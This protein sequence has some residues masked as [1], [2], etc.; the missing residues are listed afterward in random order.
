[1]IKAK[2][3]I[4]NKMIKFFCGDERTVND[5]RKKTV[6]DFLHIIDSEKL[7]EVLK[8][9]ANKKASF[10]FLIEMLNKVAFD[11]L[12]LIEDSIDQILD[13][14]EGQFNNLGGKIF[15]NSNIEEI[16]VGAKDVI[17]SDKINKNNA[18]IAIIATDNI[19][20]VLGIIDEQYINTEI[21][22]LL[23]FG[24]IFDSYTII[25]FVLKNKISKLNNLERFIIEKPFID[26][27]QAFQRKYETIYRECKEKY[28]L[29]LYMRG[30]YSYWEKESQNVEEIKELITKKCIIETEKYL[31]KFEKNIKSTSVITPIDK[32]KENNVMIGSTRGWIST[33]KYYNKNIEILRKNSK[34][35][36]AK[37]IF[38]TNSKFEK[39][40][41]NIEYLLEEI[42]NS[43]V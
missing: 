23:S 40:L 35:F 21:E 36:A 34:V 16:Y 22:K 26:N 43:R 5:Y 29:S 32:F 37:T 39:T 15:F 1:M 31:S 30:N 2:S 38:N 27:A 19:K 7:K 20:N 41:D 13:S 11:E 28:I 24:S 25:N 9:L 6:D 10:L 4:F 8:S 17:I 33:P 42:I 14:L 18:D 12:Y 3:N